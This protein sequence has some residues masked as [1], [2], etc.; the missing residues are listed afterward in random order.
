[1]LI[2]LLAACGRIGFDPTGGITSMRDADDDGSTNGDAL[3]TGDARGPD[4]QTAACAT[5]MPVSVGITQ[6]NT[7]TGNFD[8]ID[9]CGPA[10]TREIVFRFAPTTT[11]NYTIQTR[12]RG[13]MNVFSTGKV[14]AACTG[15]NGCTGISSTNHTA[16]QTYYF[17]IEDPQGGCIDIDFEIQ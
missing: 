13:T 11:R 17:V 4:A 10:G 3:N 2:V 16:G 12:F 7:C 1:M 9:G 15:N 5:A 14:D 8:R 6:A